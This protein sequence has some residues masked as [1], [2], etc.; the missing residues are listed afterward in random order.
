MCSR[1]GRPGRRFGRLGSTA[2]RR[3]GAGLV[4]AWCTT[5]AG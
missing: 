1:S 2:W 5:G 3:D 4:L